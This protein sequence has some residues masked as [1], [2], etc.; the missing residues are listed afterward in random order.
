MARNDITVTSSN[1]I[2]LSQEEQDYLKSYL[3]AGDRA[4]FYIAYY[5]LTGNSND[6]AIQQAQISTFSEDVGG[7]AFAANVWLQNESIPD[8]YLGIYYLSQEVA[9][10]AFGED[11][12][13]TDIGP[14]PEGSILDS[15]ESGGTGY[16]DGD[17][18]FNTARLAW[19]NNN[20]GGNFPGNYKNYFAENN[21]QIDATSV[22][23]TALDVLN[24]LVAQGFTPQDLANSIQIV[25]DAFEDNGIKASFFGIMRGLILGKQFSDFDG[26]AGYTTTKSP[27]G[28]LTIVTQDSTGKIVG[29]FNDADITSNILG[30]GVEAILSGL[31]RIVSGLD[32][33]AD[34]IKALSNY[35][36]LLNEPFG[37]NDDPTDTD[38]LN[39]AFDPVAFELITDT[40]SS[41]DTN[42][43]LW[44]TKE[45]DTLNG[46]A[47]NDFIFG[48]NKGD[49][50]RGGTGNDVVYGQDGGDHLF[51]DAGNDV[52]RGGKGGDTLEGGDGD[53]VLDGGDITND[54]SG[55][56]ILI[57]GAD[58]D[59]LVGGDGSDVLYGDTREFESITIGDDELYG[60]SG[61]DNLYGGGGDDTLVGGEDVDQLY[62][63]DGDD[64]LY[65]GTITTDA[66]SS[67]VTHIE[68]SNINI[69]RGGDGTDTYHVGNGDIIIDS[70]GLGSVFFKGI[71]LENG[72][73]QERLINIIINTETETLF[74]D[75]HGDLY[76]SEDNNFEYRHSGGELVV[77]YVG[78]GA[79][80][81]DQFTIQNFNI[82][83]GGYLGFNLEGLTEIGTHNT[84]NTPVE[85]NLYNADDETDPLAPV[86]VNH[87]R[88][89]RAQ[90]D[91]S[92][93]I[94]SNLDDHIW[95]RLGN[96]LIL[97]GGGSDLIKDSGGVNIIHGGAGDD[98]IIP[99]YPASAVPTGWNF[100]SV[101]ADQP[102]QEIE[103]D[104]PPGGLIFWHLP[105]IWESNG[106]AHLGNNTI[107]GEEGNDFVVAG[108]GEDQIFGGV[109]HDSISGGIGND[110]I[111]GGIGNDLLY[112]DQ[113]LL[114]VGSFGNQ[115]GVAPGSIPVGHPD[116]DRYFE[117]DENEYGTDVIFG[118]EGNDVIYGGYLDDFVDGGAGDDD[119]WLGPQDNLNVTDINGLLLNLLP[120][121]SDISTGENTGFG[122]A[123]NDTI[124]GGERA[125]YIDGG[126]GDDQ[127]FGTRWR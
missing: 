19:V 66:S 62:G 81:E 72:S 87:E 13:H 89:I 116:E 30:Q 65:S 31:F 82:N 32:E 60:G 14:T 69:L 107:Y 95:G 43:T 28:N 34:V 91:G 83:T 56:D 40:N 124:R 111:D 16:I 90:W 8:T 117:L 79:Q 17:K 15:I 49:V 73:F 36:I 92:T 120:D 78:V 33:F 59:I 58:G 61:G 48:G 115:I 67:V 51:G 93:I 38:T 99:E 94:A 123:G 98:A 121:D 24:G 80:P 70:D 103:Y 47:G 105:N 25:V 85:N 54:A 11:V 64:I 126:S 97:A 37:D 20:L 71:Q 84:V 2:V 125:D 68:D 108:N 96:N 27:D 52:L 63:N 6:Q 29:V 5:N 7:T 23:G 1:E 35:R 86:I 57:G 50:L 42:D 9:E 3:E 127:L 122:G 114:Q 119:I 88:S 76:V 22:L 10:H 101:G 112:G 113:L 104:T 118:G 100:V 39:P 110:F 53:D 41:N 21:V 12:T 74:E 46:F 109:G 55:D 77:T 106:G 75:L 102:Y 44:G 18:I 26:K 4:G 45:Q